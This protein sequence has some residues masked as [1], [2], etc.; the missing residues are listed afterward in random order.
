MDKFKT[1]N[2]LVSNLKENKNCLND[3]YYL[4]SKNQKRKLNKT[5]LK[6]IQD[7]LLT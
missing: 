1:L 7:F 2:N 3:L 6:N 4:T 5:C